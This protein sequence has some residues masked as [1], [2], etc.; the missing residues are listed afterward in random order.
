MQRINC[1]PHIFAFVVGE[2]VSGKVVG[3]QQVGDNGHVSVTTYAQLVDTAQRRLFNL[4]EKLTERYA[5][6]TGVELAKKPK[7]MELSEHL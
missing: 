2:T 4:R 1:N 7:Q 3:K 6:V 5:G